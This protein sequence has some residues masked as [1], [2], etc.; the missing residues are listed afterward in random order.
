MVNLKEN[1]SKIIAKLSASNKTISTMESCT[2]GALAS[3]ITDVS[4]ASA[5]FKYGAVTYSNEYKIKMGVSSE[6]IDKYSVY[7]METAREMAMSIS[8]FTSSDYGIGITGKLGE[9]D[10]NNLSGDNNRVFICIYDKESD[11]YIDLDTYVNSSNRVDD[12][13]EVLEFIV[14]K[15]DLYV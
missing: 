6:V 15:L 5:V 14:S 1:L 8:K 3:L 4:G 13:K 11:K 2:G 12:K 10:P 9:V 7:S